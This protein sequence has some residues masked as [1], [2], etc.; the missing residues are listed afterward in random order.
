MVATGISAPS[1]EL[2]RTA[3]APLSSFAILKTIVFRH[4]LIEERTFSRPQE[5]P[6]YGWTGLDLRD[7]GIAGAAELEG[8]GRVALTECR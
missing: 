3:L 1:S 4:T 5:F 8:K 6:G 2:I 7:L